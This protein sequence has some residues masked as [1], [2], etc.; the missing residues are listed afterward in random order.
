MSG[1]LTSLFFRELSRREALALIDEHIVDED[2]KKIILDVEAEPG[3][4]VAYKNLFS[5]L[6]VFPVKLADDI[7][8]VVS[9]DRSR[10]WLRV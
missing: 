6:Y 7:L 2:F 10:F 3:F 5:G 4:S 8:L 9:L 1:D